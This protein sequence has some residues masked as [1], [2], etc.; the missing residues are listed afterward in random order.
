M[1]TLVV[2]IAILMLAIAACAPAKTPDASGD[3]AGAAVVD[4]GI[5]PEWSRNAVL[6]EVNIRQYTPSGTL[7][8]FTKELP[9]LKALGIDVLWIMPVQPIGTLNRKGSLGSYYSIRDY[10][11]IN[12]EFGTE[13]DFRALV[14]AAHVQGMKVILD[15]VANHTAFDHEWASAHKDWYTL[16][17]DGTI[18]RAIGGDGKE[19]DWSDVA[20]LNYA[21]SEMR[22][23]M[24]GEM[25]WWVDSMAIDGFRCDMAGLV[26]ADFWVE[27]RTA[28][29][30]VRP[31]LFFLAEWEDPALHRSFDAT[32][33]WKL[34]HT[35]ND[36]AQG[37]KTT[38]EF[39]RYFAEQDST[40]GRDAYRLYFT[41]NHDENSWAGTEF[42]RM[43][44]NHQPAFVVSALSQ[45][46]LPLLYSGQEA[47]F[48]RRLA[49]FEKDS[50]DWTGPSLADFYR[51]IF[52]LRHSEEVLWNGQWGAP[53]TELTTD[54]GD[55]VWAFVR[56][57]GDRAV[58]VVTNFAETPASVKYTALAA[59]GTYTDAFSK[60]SVTL[61]SDG[62]I[63]VP[64]NGYRILVK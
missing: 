25:R 44:A 16:R 50:I 23:A 40:F 60:A 61:A 11:A 5:H 45:N 62:V 42:E 64:A 22:A 46:A 54:G 59:T 14:D 24:I 6:Y 57:R 19:T 29:D 8:A 17:P 10:T 12:P 15:W 37:K 33:G 28:I 48:S 39:R 4:P 56:A 27:V 18:S 26:P 58:V 35:M 41:S 43:G 1:R 55:R 36:V 38:A 47:S 53:Q 9:R 34:F 30:A 51:T 20:D 52:A 3:G 21:S 7:A 49:F 13:A 31:G 32:Y 63:D 2:V